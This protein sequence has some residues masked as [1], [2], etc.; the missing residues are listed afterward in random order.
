MDLSKNSKLAKFTFYG[1]ELTDANSFQTIK[2]LEKLTHLNFRNNN[3]VSY[4]LTF[5]TSLV[6]LQELI[7]NNNNFIGSLQ[8]LVNLTKLESLDIS[9]TDLNSGAEY[10]PN[11]LDRIYY[12][13][14]LRPNSR[15]VE[16]K[17]Q[18]DQKY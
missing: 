4:D 17:E 13:A 10:L 2:S 18:L 1:N 12:S 9:N 7:L 6:N 15:L 8:P 11:S 5:L 3:F 14:D 16:I